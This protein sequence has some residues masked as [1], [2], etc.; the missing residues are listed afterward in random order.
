MANDTCTSR[1]TTLADVGLLVLRIAIGATLLQAGLN[2]FFDF[3]NTALLM[4]QSGWQLPKVATVMVSF[5]EAGGGALLIVG[6]LTPLAAFAVIA[7]MLDAWAVDVSSMSLW[8]QP[9]NH[10]FAL[11]LGGVTVLFAGPGWLSVDARVW[12]AQWPAPVALAL[13]LVAS[14]VAV[15]TW[16][17]LNGANPIHFTT[18]A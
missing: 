2:K 3:N 12:R 6:L 4:A 7:V 10:P 9:F 11:A 1:P 18:P 14:L 15:V 16:V 13:L 17:A 8:E 5:A